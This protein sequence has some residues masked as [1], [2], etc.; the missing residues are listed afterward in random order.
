M[1]PKPKRRPGRPR[2]QPEHP[3]A[4]EQV[5]LT[6]STCGR[7]LG[8]APG[9]HAIRVDPEQTRDYVARGVRWV[10]IKR[11]YQSCECGRNFCVQAPIRVIPL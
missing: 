3:T 4:L 6:C 2:K 5:P 11:W 9:K 8:T 10:G 7:N 1:T